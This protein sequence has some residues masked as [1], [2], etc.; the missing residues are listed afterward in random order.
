MSLSYDIRKPKEPRHHTI[1]NSYQVR[2]YYIWYKRKS[3]TKIKQCVFTAI[4][5]DCI[6]DLVDS[7]LL[8]MLN[9]VLPYAMG[10]VT[11]KVIPLTITHDNCGRIMSSMPIDWK[12]TMLLWE[13]DK[14]CF[15]KRTLLRSKTNERYRI[16]YLKPKKRYHNQRYYDIMFNRNIKRKV[17]KHIVTNDNFN[18]NG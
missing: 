12:N 7:C 4:F 9:I 1:K 17:Y 16:I 18:L 13:N 3:K 8:Q 2:D 10:Y 6:N 11:I 15:E 5:K 14:E